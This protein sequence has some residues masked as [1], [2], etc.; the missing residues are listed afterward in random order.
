METLALVDPDNRRPVD[1]ARRQ[2]AVGDAAEP[3]L[4]LTQ[5]ALELRRRRADAFDGDYEPVD[6]GDG[7]CAFVR[8]GEV[9][10]VVPVRDVPLPAAPAGWREI[11]GGELGVGLYERASARSA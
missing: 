3:K 8:G 2:R 10:V 6:M 7:V 9:L 4:W 1:W 5:Q 11:I